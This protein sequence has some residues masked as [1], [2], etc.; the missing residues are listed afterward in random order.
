MIERRSSQ[1][2]MR[3]INPFINM[4]LFMFASTA[5]AIDNKIEGQWTFVEDGTVIELSS[6]SAKPD[7]LCA[8]IVRH[9]SLMEKT[10]HKSTLCG[11]LLLGDLQ[12]DN[13]PELGAHHYRGWIID[14]EETIQG[15]TLARY[16][17]TLTLKSATKAQINVRAGFFT[18]N[19]ELVRAA[20]PVTSCR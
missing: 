7:W 18:E 14:P 11:L 4:L 10:T 1:V 20:I 12:S 17:A 9:P 2:I 15:K 19:H 5:I 13:R 8:A 16:D 3:R 6:C